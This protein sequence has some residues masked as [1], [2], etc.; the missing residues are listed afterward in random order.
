MSAMGWKADITSGQS[1]SANGVEPVD[2]HFSFVT[3]EVS[4]G[5]RAQ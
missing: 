2:N 5:A 3:A 1:Q 4:K